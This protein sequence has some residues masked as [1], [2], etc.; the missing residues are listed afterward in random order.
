MLK[1][2]ICEPLQNFLI[3]SLNCEAIVSS[4]KSLLRRNK[5]SMSRVEAGNQ[6]ELKYIQEITQ[7]RDSSFKLTILSLPCHLPSAVSSMPFCTLYRPESTLHIQ[8]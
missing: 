4:S 8:T 1:N 6:P 2:V 5:P 7:S 3:L